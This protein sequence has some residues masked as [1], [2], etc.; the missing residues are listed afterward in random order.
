MTDFDY[1]HLVLVEDDMALAELTQ[2]FLQAQ[3]YKVTHLSDGPTAAEQIPRIMPDCVLLDVM[4]PGLDGIEVC[5]Q[6]RP[7]FQ[8]VVIFLTAKGDAFDEVMG[9]EVGG[10][11]YLAKPIEPRIM[12][13]HIRAQLRRHARSKLPIAEG[14]AAQFDIHAAN[15]AISYR[16]QDLL[17]SQPEFQLLALLLQSQ[18]EIISRDDVSLAVRGIEY[19]GLSRMVDILVSDLRKKLPDPDWI[20]TIRG[21]G[22]VWRGPS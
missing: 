17:L 2:T 20:K 16:G 12:L 19:D 3:G 15:E 11:D 22:Y 14:L 4:L 10:D 21:K 9:L 18:S 1:A 8:G 13:A 7:L 5:R 6:I